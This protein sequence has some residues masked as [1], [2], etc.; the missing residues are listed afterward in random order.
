M[1]VIGDVLDQVRQGLLPLRCEGVDGVDAEGPQKLLGQM[2]WQVCR[3]VDIDQIAAD[4]PTVV[5]DGA[6]LEDFT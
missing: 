3:Q 4:G 5:A 1:T 2:W 6:V